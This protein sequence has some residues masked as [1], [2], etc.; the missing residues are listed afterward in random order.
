MQC[1]IKIFSLMSCL[2][3]SDAHRWNL[4]ISKVWFR[5]TM[6]QTFCKPKWVSTA[7][8]KSN[9]VIQESASNIDLA[10]TT[11]A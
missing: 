11:S 8:M 6:P 9:S 5:V 3:F 1:T 2:A 4:R 7:K 10:G